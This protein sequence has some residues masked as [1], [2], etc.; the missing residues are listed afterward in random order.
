MEKFSQNNEQ[1]VILDY[2]GDEKITVLS[3]G[4]NEGTFLSNV[5][6]LLLN[7]SRGTLVEPA[8]EAFFKLTELYADRKDVFCINVAV[9]DYIGNAVFY[10][11]GEHLKCGDKSLLSSLNENEIKKWKP[12]T[13]FNEIRVDVVDFKT[14]LNLS[15]YKQFDFIS[16]DAE[17][18]DLTILQQINLK[19]LGCRM[20]CIEW[21][22]NPELLDKMKAIC[23]GFGLSKMLLKNAEN[24]IMAAP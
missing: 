15:P 17:G 16:V 21:N 8:P 13:K 5:R 20:L 22:S 23:E 1:S 24:V 10:D 19:E 14:F 11:S 9:S 4:E 12:T 2:F 6:A 18:V 3:I 7:G